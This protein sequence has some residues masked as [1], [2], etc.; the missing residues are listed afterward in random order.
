MP[1]ICSLTGTVVTIHAAAPLG[2][3]NAIASLSDDFCGG[4]NDQSFTITIYELVN[5]CPVLINPPASQI[6]ASV[7]TTYSFPSSFC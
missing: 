5:E 6:F 7:G 2:T 1:G 3:F 4:N